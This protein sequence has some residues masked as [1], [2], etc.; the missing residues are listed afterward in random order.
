MRIANDRV[1]LKPGTNVIDI[2]DSLKD[3]GYHGYDVIVPPDTPPGDPSPTNNTGSPFTTVDAPGK[4]LIVRGKPD[5]PNF[6]TNA[7]KSSGLNVDTVGGNAIPAS[8][9]AFAQYDCVI[10]DDVN[11]GPANFSP[12]QMQ[13]LA[14]WVKD[15]GG[16][17]LIIRGDDLVGPGV[18]MGP[19]IEGVAP[20][21]MDVKRKKHISSLAIVI[22]NDKSGSMGVHPS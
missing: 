10:L 5:N 14:K 15:Y 21:A 13:D 22:V 7:L 19:P 17:L 2:P 4:V 3:G 16:G 6:L 8:V 20:V 9:K 18:Y 1:N 11:A 12:G